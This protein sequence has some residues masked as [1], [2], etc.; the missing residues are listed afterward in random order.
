[1]SYRS[2]ICKEA[3]ARHFGMETLEKQ[4]EL[5][6]AMSETK[7]VTGMD[8]LISETKRDEVPRKRS[9]DGT[10]NALLPKVVWPD[11]QPSLRSRLMDRLVLLTGRRKWWASAAV[12]QER[13]RKL[14]L[15]PAPHCPVRLGRNVKVDLRFAE[16]W[17][18]YH[19]E[20]A[21]SAS[22]RHH[23]IFLHGGGYVH[24]IVGSHWSFIAYLVDETHAHCIV[25]IYPLAP[26]G[27]AKEVVPATGRMLRDLI[28]AVGAQNMT[29]VGN[30]AGGGLSLAAVQWLR[31]AGHPQPN[32]L[33]LICPG[34]DATLSQCTQADA[35]RDVM[36]DVP[37]MIQAF[38]MY[39]GDLDVTHPFVSPLNA[40]FDGLA[41]MLIFT[42]THD[43]FHPD[44]VALANKAAGA[45]VPV[46]M[47]VRNGLQ[48]NY[49][50]LLTPEGRE[51]RGIIARAIAAAGSGK[52]SLS[53]VEALSS[54][55]S[56]YDDLYKSA[57]R[58]PD[59]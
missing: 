44:I 55:P 53:T 42:G 28:Q 26:R 34:V 1:M 30:S 32:A 7:E 54:S 43:L 11:V 33:I 38:R 22:V 37:G 46:E 20:P 51:A 59:V 35:A 41:P 18:V 40:D 29:V 23:V 25:P 13:V 16:G 9:A 52:P 19:V 8:Q 36:Q 3:A 17:P 12:V 4:A 5:V 49:P 6:L 14:A 15:R 58:Q 24:E 56:R 21:R 27:T 39:A 45:G 48:H 47:H 50:L 57:L 10:S 31:E 2:Y